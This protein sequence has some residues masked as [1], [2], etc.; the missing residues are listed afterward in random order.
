MDKNSCFESCRSRKSAITVSILF[1]IVTILPLVAWADNPV[2][3][4]PISNADPAPSVFNDTVFMYNTEEKD[5]S[6]LALKTHCFSTTDM[7][8]WKDEG[9]ALDEANIPWANKVTPGH[10][11]APHVVFY[12]GKYHYYAPETASN[13]KF[14]N[15]HAVASNP[16]GPFIPDAQPMVINGYRS[17]QPYIEDALDPFCIMDTGAGGSGNNYLAWCITNLTPNRL[18]IGKLNETMDSVI[19]MPT[20]LTSTNFYPDGAHYVEGQWWVKQNSTWYHFYA[21]YY[22]GGSERIGIATA[23]NLLGTYTFRGFLMGNN[24]NSAAGTIH[25]GV[26]YYKKK[27]YLFWHCGG[28][29]YGGSLLPT[30]YMRSSGV[31]EFVFN[32]TTSPWAVVSPQ[33]PNVLWS[34]PK[35]YRGIGIPQVND[36]IQVDRRRLASDI[37]SASV[38]LVDASEPLGYMLNRIGNNG[39]VRY[40]SVDF[41]PTGIDS[42]VGQVQARVSSTNANNSI[43]VRL[44]SNT[45]TLLASIA[46]PNTGSLTKWQTTAWAPLSTTAT[47]GVHNIVLVFKGTAN[48]MNVNWIKFGQKFS[49]VAVTRGKKAMPSGATC[50]RTGVNSFVVETANNLAIPEVSLIN[51]KGQNAIQVAQ[52]RMADQKS[53]A[54]KFDASRLSAGVYVLMV[55]DAGGITRM[56]FVY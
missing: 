45:G 10:L 23:T 7:Y 29:E 32:T 55:K 49:G 40:D 31:E 20:Q 41:T 51:L 28:A 4:L 54:V 47:T 22:P 5:A 14:Y 34:I 27:W 6:L 48:T 50:R 1:M 2:I 46:V 38:A 25:P 3:T 8:Q 36:M 56:P 15:L 44:G 33:S 42:V 39:W 12:K 53:I 24:S 43:E 35:T 13:G 19:G 52:T 30:A 17:G 26:C 9:V 21:V 18:Y 16:R 11:W 37:S